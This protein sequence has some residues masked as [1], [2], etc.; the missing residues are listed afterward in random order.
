MANNSAGQNKEKMIEE[1][2]EDLA[3]DTKLFRLRFKHRLWKLKSDTM[4]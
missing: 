1:E 3:Y 4:E 2:M